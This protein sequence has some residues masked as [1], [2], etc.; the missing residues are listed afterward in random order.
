MTKPTCTH[1]LLAAVPLCATLFAVAQ[2]PA[3]AQYL[4]SNNMYGTIQQDLNAG[5]LS[6]GQANS[7]MNQNNS[8]MQR[9]A[10]LLRNDGGVLTPNDQNKLAKQAARDQANL[11][12]DVNSNTNG[13]TGVG[14]LL[15]TLF[16]TNSNAPYYNNGLYNNGLYNNGLYN[17]GID[18]YGNT[19]NTAYPYNPASPYGAGSPYLNGA[20]PYYNNGL[21]GYNNGI[22][23]SSTTYGTGYYGRYRHNHNNW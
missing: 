11:L 1:A 3:H 20:S 19:Y 21:Y 14:G 17:N 2:Q 16:G 5:L 13:G 15:G 4:N 7:L 6:P 23:P 10:R 22:Y 12:N 18:P 9:A 8:L